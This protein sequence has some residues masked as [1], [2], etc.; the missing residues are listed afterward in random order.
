MSSHTHHKA[1][2]L[3]QEQRCDLVI[4]GMHCASCAN[5]ITKSLKKVPGVKDANV[6][7]AT[8]QATVTYDPHAAHTDH[9]VKAV[10]SRG[11]SAQVID[12]SAHGGHAGGVHFDV[13]EL[14]GEREKENLHRARNT[15]LFSLLFTIPAFIIG[16][17][18]MSDG[19]FSVGYEL[20]YAG[21]VL[22][23][24]A[25]PVQFI[26]GAEF[27]KGTWQ[28]L[29]NFSAG[30]DTLIAMG[31]TAAYLFSAWAVFFAPMGT[32]QYFE[33]AMVIITL[34][35]LGRYLELR[36]KGKTNEAIKKLLSLAPKMAT[37][38]RNGKEVKVAVDD[39]QI[40]DIIL[41]RPGENIPVDGIITEGATTID[42]SMV[43]GESMPVEKKRG[44]VVISG[45]SNKHGS[46]HMKATKVGANTTLAKIVKLI[47]DAQGRKAPIQRFADTI[48]A[49]FVPAVIVIAVVTLAYW[50][51]ASTMGFEFGLVAAVSVLV[52]A[53]PCALGLATP[54]AILV[55]TGKG[56]Q[57][58]ILIKGGDALETAHKL[59]S[60][61]FDKTG[62]ITNGKPVV[63]NVLS[64]SKVTEKQLL[65]V[66]A[67]I[68]QGSEH[69][70]AE[71][72]VQKA[73]HDNLKLTKATGFTAIPGHGIT[74]KVGVNTYFLGN[75]KLMTKKGV[76]FS[77]HVVA[78][79][80]LEQ[81]GKTVMLL[82]KGKALIGAVAVA[83][84]MKE[85]APEAIAQLQKLGLDVYMITGDN[86]R[87][88][89]A[90]AKQAGIPAS[91]VFAEVLPED[92]SN[93]VK[94]LQENGKYKVAMVGDGIND[95]P[96]LAQ[97]DIGIAMGSGTD[98]AMETGNVVLMRND[99]RDVP[100][101]IKLSKLTMRKIK[102]N[103]FWA[104]IYN[105]LGIP[106]AAGALYYS[107][108]TL[109]SPMIAGAAM[110]ASSVSV[111]SNSLLLK[112]QKL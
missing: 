67:S 66:A 40:G 71:A 19:L 111:V 60:V 61:L 41:V 43:T 53:C 1:Q 45:T 7:Y 76:S 4:G 105:V 23:L 93:Y 100:K 6:N 27:Y 98:V 68:E 56:A 39:V 104:F 72:I 47:E 38:L 81:D 46:F 30:M 36:A 103:L 21:F 42:E 63:T 49:Y 10:E 101:A 29:K 34:I 24:L 64:F 26:A 94:K 78:M 106:V 88:A 77:K 11:Y 12:H 73:K 99:L 65:Q 13:H 32:G 80:S 90:I 16:M 31:T 5:I 18:F 28:S 48:S 22:F 51:F 52:I 8:E 44:A 37:V 59:R 89:K 58:G 107:T 95:A 112:L 55:G 15:F 75:T 20:P 33:T 69:P 50:A 87:T 54:T 57:E 96:A 91:H 108:G 25:T 79:Q 70:L 35:L 85:N 82:A 97:A 102:Q 110:A 9:L 83:D 17:F 62:T 2:H 14:K 84:T 109:L 86:E 3:E 92:K 74:A